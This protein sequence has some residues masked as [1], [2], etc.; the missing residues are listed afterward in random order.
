MVEN[1]VT[2]PVLGVAFDGTGY[3][4]DGTIWGGEFLL[5]AYDTFT[6]L[7]HL[8]YLPLP[9][10]DG[11]VKRP[12]RTTVGYL[13]TLLGPESLS[14]A[15]ECVKGIGDAEV[16]LI[17]KQVMKKI[18]TPLTS[19]AG[20]LFDAASSL[21]GIRQ[22]IDYEGQ[23]AIELE[24]T[25]TDAPPDDRIYP[26]HIVEADGNRVIRLNAL[27]SSLLDDV[28]RG[29]PKPIMAWRFHCTVAELIARVCKTLSTDCG[30]KQVALSGGVFQNRLLL[31]RTKRALLDRGLHVLIHRDL[32]CN[33]GCISLGQAVIAGW[34]VT[35]PGPV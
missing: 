29:V 5:V 22:V 33:D 6:R 2:E 15:L 18:N 21:M 26:F 3:G 32:P 14:P 19:S 35:H 23:A 34:K 11:A 7:A 17:K 10:G 4:A 30:V 20:R 27:F 12:Y 13:L 25:A 28:R 16:D 24:M 8:E 1:G 31:R 9:G